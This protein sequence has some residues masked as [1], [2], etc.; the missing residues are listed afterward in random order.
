MPLNGVQIV[1]PG[2]EYFSSN[3]KSFQSFPRVMAEILEETLYE[4]D[5]IALKPPMGPKF[6]TLHLSLGTIC[7]RTH[8]TSTLNHPIQV[9][10]FSI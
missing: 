4:K 10:N 2:F 3:G 6:I 1:V 7:T 9:P 5:Y 8:A